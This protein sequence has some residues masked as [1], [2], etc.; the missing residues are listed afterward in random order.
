MR[1]P[2]KF[3]IEQHDGN[4][5]RVS[6]VPGSE[7]YD[8]RTQGISGSLDRE[9][10]G[11]SASNGPKGK[12]KGKGKSYIAPSGNLEADAVQEIVNQ[13][14]ATNSGKVWFD[15]WRDR[16][17]KLGPTAREFMLSR[18][19]LFQLEFSGNAFTVTFIGNEEEIAA[20]R[21]QTSADSR[22]PGK[23]AV[24]NRKDPMAGNLLVLA[25]ITMVA[26]GPLCRYFRR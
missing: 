2:K 6:I 16:Y 17:R 22:V 1:H 8:W 7:N 12:G 11:S 19:D 18:P 25:I 3:A 23:V 10:N 4:R 24:Q 26:R 20:L 5:F 14:R 13:L 21:G 9:Y 15:D